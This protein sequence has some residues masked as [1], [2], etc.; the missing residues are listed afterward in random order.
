MP[1]R[2]TRREFTTITVRKEDLTVIANGLEDGALY[3]EGVAA[4]YAKTGDCVEV[5]VPAYKD[6]A[7]VYRSL[8]RAI[9]QSVE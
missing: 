7:R 9:A 3:C 1:R 2:V 8:S 4:V 5:S 6:R